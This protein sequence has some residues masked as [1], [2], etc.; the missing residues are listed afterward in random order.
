MGI[1]TI[2]SRK[3]QTILRLRALAGDGAFRRQQGEYLCDGRKLLQ[4][5]LDHGAVLRTVRPGASHFSR[6]LRSR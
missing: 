2:T 3:N 5:A 6:C 1:E 4:E